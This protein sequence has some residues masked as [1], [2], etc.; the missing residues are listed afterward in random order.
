MEIGVDPIGQVLH[1]CGSAAQA[2]YLGQPGKT[3]TAGMAVPIPIIDVP[4]EP[5][6]RSRA[7]GMRTGADHAHI[8]F[9]DVDE[10][11]QFVDAGPAYDIAHSRNSRIAATGGLGAGRIAAVLTHAAELD[12]RK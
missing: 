7:D 1:T 12:E 10:L 8:P 5:V 11:G 3:W 2:V 6:F 4:E 9:Q